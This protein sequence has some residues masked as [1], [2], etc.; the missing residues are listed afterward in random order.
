MLLPSKNFNCCLLISSLT[1]LILLNFLNKFVSFLIKFLCLLLKMVSPV[2]LQLCRPLLIT[3]A[4][5]LWELD[6]CDSSLL[7]LVWERASLLIFIC[8]KHWSCV[9]IT[10]KLG[11]ENIQSERFSIYL[12]WN[13]KG[14]LTQC[15]YIQVCLC[16]NL[17]SHKKQ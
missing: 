17:T 1:C 16:C 12:I 7:T 3:P 5:Y 15:W 10:E 4:K 11:W 13:S 2:V 14:Y 8:N 6:S 9:R